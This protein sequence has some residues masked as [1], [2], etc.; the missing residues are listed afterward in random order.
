MPT[1]TFFRLPQEK[2]TRLLDAALEEFSRVPFAQVS[3]NKIIQGAGIPRGSFYMYFAD[4]ED[5]FRHL[6]GTYRQRLF[7]LCCQE[8]D[9]CGGD[10]FAT[11]EEIH[12]RIGEALAR[13]DLC[14]GASAR[15]IAILRLNSALSPSLLLD[16]L[17]IGEEEPQREFLDLL[18]PH[19]DLSL[20]SLEAESDLEDILHIL[21][22]ITVSS[23]AAEAASGAGP[24][25]TR[26]YHQT[27]QLLKRG[28]AAP[29]P[30]SH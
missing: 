2:R 28:M 27:L 23:L 11:F 14:S 3:I 18:T 22:G 17:Q 8:L 30:T 7:R 29:Q 15:L 5:L 20:L 16:A 26:H 25:Q 12:A 4:K 10:L 21:V 19:I 9:R 6:L 13:G 24:V 1:D